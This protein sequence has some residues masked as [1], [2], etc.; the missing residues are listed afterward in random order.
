MSD[1]TVLR[2]VSV[3][4][5]NACLFIII[6]IA[7]H[8]SHHHYLSCSSPLSLL[9]PIPILSLFTLFMHVWRL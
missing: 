8:L 3:P 1:Y 9:F 7:L 4:L 6:S 2:D 5:S